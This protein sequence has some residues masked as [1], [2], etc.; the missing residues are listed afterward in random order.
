[1]LHLP[2][3]R[4]AQFALAA[5]LIASAAAQAAAEDWPQWRGP[6]RDGVWNETGI[7]EKL[8]DGQIPIKWRVEIGAGYSGPTVA[9]G[10]VYVTDRLTK[11]QEV[12]RVHCFDEKTGDPI[13]SHSYPCRY[14]K[15]GYNAGP[16]ASVGIDDGKAYSLG[17]TGRL[18]CF[19]AASGEIVW[20]KDLDAEYDIQMPIWGIAALA[21]D[22]P[23]P[24]DRADRREEGV[25]RGA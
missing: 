23:R 7:V 5:A 18:F 9:K 4:F 16:R 12:E 3:A 22:L 24:G 13:W 25:H 1:M 6:N 10:R 15:I 2:A 8:P 21:A 14:G 11:P 17:G 20:E 19:D